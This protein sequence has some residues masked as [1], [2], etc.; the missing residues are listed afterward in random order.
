MF[1]GHHSVVVW[2]I[3][4]LTKQADVLL[5][6]AIV[7]AGWTGRGVLS[8]Y[9]VRR[10]IHQRFVFVILKRLKKDQNICTKIASNF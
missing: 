1:N 6:P 9:V 2:Q 10:K 3:L 5:L 8:I 4:L 7:A